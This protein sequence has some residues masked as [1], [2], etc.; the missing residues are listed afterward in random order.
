MKIVGI[1][2]LTLLDYPEK[3]A[4]TVFL[5]GCNF[6]CP[7]CHNGQ[8]LGFDAD[9][10]MSADELL[11]FL[12]KRIGLLEGVCITGG[13][14][15][16]NDDIFPLLKSIKDMG[17]SVKLDTN[18]SVPNALRRILEERLADYVA[19]DIKNAPVHYGCTVG[20]DGFDVGAIEES[21]RLLTQDVVSYEFRTTVVKQ[22]HDSDSISAMGS[23]VSSVAGGKKAA[24]WFVQPFVDRETVPMAG[25]AA[26][27]DKELAYFVEILKQYAECAAL[28][29]A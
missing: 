4:C 17:Y 10:I 2:K 19:M 25:L 24:K 22:L 3:V 7:F 18:G 16:L 21:I 13:E 6:R 1:Q 12:Q 29:G 26:P 23:W 15:L 5:G 9:Q 28:R 14:P 20:L 27:D 11:S 8:L